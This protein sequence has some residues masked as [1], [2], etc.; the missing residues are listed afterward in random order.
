MN[1][2]TKTAGFFAAVAAGALI[3]AGCS[4][5]DDG[6]GHSMDSMG[7]MSMTTSAPPAESSSDRNAADVMWTQMMIPHHQQAVEMAALAQGRTENAELLEL[8]SRIQAAQDPEIE[9]MTS[10]L[11][12]WG[13]PTMTNEGMDHSSM[14]DMGDMSGM[15]SADDMAT[16]EN[17]IGAEFD[18]AWL[19][20]MIAH[21]QGAI[22]SSRA[23]Q[24]NGTN[25][26]VDELAGKIV[27][28]QQAEIEQMKAMLGQ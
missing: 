4:D 16:L 19:E 10:W 11:T 18:R 8:A 6:A 3:V 17:A 28:G 5:S 25:E 7:S 12:A 21:H 14:G 15:M 26:Q 24:A 2:R 23:I 27:A 20:M 9:L 22:D 13:E 1:T